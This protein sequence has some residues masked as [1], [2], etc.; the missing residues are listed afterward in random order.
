MIE[1]G[2]DES[3]SF[4]WQALNQMEGRLGIITDKVDYPLMNHLKETLRLD[5]GIVVQITT[6]ERTAVV[7]D[8]LSI[9]DF[10]GVPTENPDSIF[11]SIRMRWVQEYLKLLSYINKK[12]RNSFIPT[13]SYRSH[14]EGPLMGYVRSIKNM[15]NE[16][17]KE[18]LLNHFT[19]LEKVRWFRSEE[20]GFVY[21]ITGDS[22][23]ELLESL[24]IGA[25]SFWTFINTTEEENPIHLMLDLNGPLFKFPVLNEKREFIEFPVSTISKLSFDFL[26]SVV[27][28]SDGIFPMPES[29][30]E[31]YIFDT[32]PKDYDL[33]Q[34]YPRILMTHDKDVVVWMHENNFRELNLVLAN[35]K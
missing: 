19:K 18:I 34:N 29:A 11:G 20:E 10:E 23:E 28:K 33:S 31:H 17:D 32:K 9:M 13:S 14:A 21:Q 22:E 26:V 27:I 8:F 1:I 6:E 4:N 15:E 12:D 7:E 16:K 30:V 25:W 5:E 3:G 24:F 2:K 35:E